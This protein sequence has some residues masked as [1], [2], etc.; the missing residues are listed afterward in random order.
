MPGHGSQG[1]RMSAALCDLLIESDHIKRGPVLLMPTDGI[2]RL[3]VGPLETVIHIGTQAAEADDGDYS[4][5]D[6]EPGHRT[7]TTVSTT[8]ALGLSLLPQIEYFNP[9]G[10]QLD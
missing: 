9:H 1:F 4:A 10:L 7:P 6:A 2:S 3:E 5:N 8:T